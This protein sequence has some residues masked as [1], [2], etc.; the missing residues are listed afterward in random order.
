M[1]LKR[2]GCFILF[3]MSPRPHRSWCIDT[4]HLLFK[5]LFSLCFSSPWPPAKSESHPKPNQQARCS[6]F[7]LMNYYFSNLEILKFSWVF[8]EEEK[9]AITTDRF[10][11]H[12]KEMTGSSWEQCLLLSEIWGE[13]F[14]LFFI[15]PQKWMMSF[16]CRRNWYSTLYEGRYGLISSKI[17]VTSWDA[18]SPRIVS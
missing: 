9:F 2:I 12:P 17:I 13:Q 18:A 16:L 15:K 4:I 14:H 5:V 8:P 3:P 11:N 7:V 6:T 10:H 1:H